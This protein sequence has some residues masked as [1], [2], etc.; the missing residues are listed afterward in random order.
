MISTELA[1]K[2]TPGNM[3][4]TEGDFS[5]A[6][7]GRVAEQES[8][9]ENRATILLK[10]I[11]KLKH[12]DAKVKFLLDN[13]NENWNILV[14]FGLDKA[15]ELINS[16]LS[17]LDPKDKEP[18]ELSKLINLPVKNSFLVFGFISNQMNETENPK[19]I[20]EVLKKGFESGGKAL[21]SLMLSTILFEQVA[22]KIKSEQSAELIVDIM[23]DQ[24]ESA[25]LSSL[26]FS[27][28]VKSFNKNILSRTDKRSGFKLLN[29]MTSRL[30]ERKLD[31]HSFPVDELLSKIDVNEIKQLNADQILTLSNSNMS[32]DQKESILNK[33][34][35]GETKA[36]I[37]GRWTPENQRQLF[38]ILLK[39]HLSEFG[40]VFSLKTK[41]ESSQKFGWTELFSGAMKV[42]GM[43]ASLRNASLGN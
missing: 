14:S 29:E 16:F 3:G 34:F 1:N 25:S 13:N 33:F 28:L 19:Y 6:V 27:G 31:F 40:K 23:Q 2:N 17:K 18:E 8:V 36:S 35:V 43:N 11:N 21:S 22:S 4:V 26:L 38:R 10:E 39:K 32:L 5:T 15:R 7:D 24:A 42:A 30:K 37:S 12:G 20:S 9:G 41:T